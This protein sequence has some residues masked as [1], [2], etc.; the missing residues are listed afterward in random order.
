MKLANG[1]TPIMAFKNMDPGPGTRDAI[2]LV[3]AFQGVNKRQYVVWNIMKD[4]DEEIWDCQSG[5]YF[6]NREEAEFAFGLRL[7][8]YH[9]NER[10]ARGAHTE[11]LKVILP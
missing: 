10:S 11:T 3:L 8:R 9:L 4:N 1:A 2:G 5:D 6:D 7:V